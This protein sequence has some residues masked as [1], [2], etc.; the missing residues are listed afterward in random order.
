[1]RNVTV[2]FSDGSQHV[3]QNAPDDVT[4]ENVTARA[5]KQFPGLTVTALDGGRKEATTAPAPKVVSREDAIKAKAREQVAAEASRRDSRVGTGFLGDLADFGTAVKASAANTFG[6]GPRIQARISALK[7][8]VPYDDALTYWREVNKAERDQSFTGDVAGALVGGGGVV[9]GANVALNAATKVAPQAGNFL[10]RIV[11]LQPGQKVRNVLR[12]GGTGA[13]AGALQAA[14]EGT[15]VSEGATAGGVVGTGLGVAGPIASRVLEAGIN[16]VASLVPKL[17][18]L[19]PSQ[20]QRIVLDTLQ[21]DG[22]SPDDAMQVIQQAQARGVPLSLSDVGDNTRGLTSSLARK[23]GEARTIVQDAIGERQ[24][25]Q[26]E[27][28]QGAL[29]R[30]LGP[31]TNLREASD[32]LIRSAKAKAA[33]LYDEAYK[34]PVAWST[35]DGI[36]LNRI[37]NTPAGKKALQKAHTIAANEMRDP[38]SLGF[39]MNDKGDVVLESV[40]TFQ[41]LDYVKR[42]LDDVVEEARDPTTGRL[43]LDTNGKAI[44]DLRGMF[45]DEL[46]RLNPKYGEALDAYSGDARMANAL[47]QGGKAVN[48]SAEDI[49]AETQ[50]MTPAELEQ[51]RLGLRSGLS[52]SIDAKGD[53]GDGIKRLIGSPKK[54]KALE[55][56]FGGQQGLAN[57]IDTMKDETAAFRTYTRSMTGSPTAANLADDQNLEMLTDLFDA[58][59]NVANGRFMNAIRVLLARKGRADK[60][61]E[62][63][64]A[65]LAQLLTET[66]PATLREVMKRIGDADIQAVQR[67]RQGS[68]FSAA[69]GMMGARDNKSTA[70]PV[71]PAPAVGPQSS[72]PDLLQDQPL[73]LADLVSRVEQAESGGDQSAVS[74]KGAVGVMQVMPATAPE[75]AQLAGVP[76]DEE[77]YRTDPEYNR[78]LGTAYLMEMLRQFDGDVVTALAAYNAGPGAVRAAQA[79]GGDW[80]AS[81]PAETQDY[82]QRVLG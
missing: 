20:A 27:R 40:P 15:D 26:G 74:P 43:N 81:L 55:Q 58:G 2:T 73:E 78:L 80:L 71:Q 53:A 7:D 61:S 28:I 60:A 34:A 4:P 23:P 31:V 62:M 44:N 70:A 47:R 32:D 24:L 10:S 69:G 66:D 75:A 52:N 77:K 21:Q 56:V 11:N 68:T 12:L 8:D 67:L 29:E 35:D 46:R 50:R 79:K 41:T 17:K 16:K 48:K 19:S 1:M 6:I 38:G 63:T 82:V 30:D 13:G 64:R 57:F 33:P 54:R 25:A 59:V 45:V 76:F 72:L 3:Y 36:T 51:Y 5:Q 14:G 18:N 42:G 65:E 39:T 37:L 22:L 49:I 9:K